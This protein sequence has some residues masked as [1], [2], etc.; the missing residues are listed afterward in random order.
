[1]LTRRTAG[2]GLWQGRTAD[3]EQRALGRKHDRHIENAPEM[4]KMEWANTSR[5]NDVAGSGGL[6]SDSLTLALPSSCHTG[7]AIIIE[8]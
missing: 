6:S 1:M 5:Q 2:A 7:L 4:M 8:K 3:L